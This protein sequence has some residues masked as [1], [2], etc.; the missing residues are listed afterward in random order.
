MPVR[1]SPVA[2]NWRNPT[3]TRCRLLHRDL[4]AARP[5]I[6]CHR[7]SGD[8]PRVQGAARVTVKRSAWP[9]TRAGRLYE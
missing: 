6:A 4:L 3:V 7:Y 8:R 1:A 2:S 5:K 9:G